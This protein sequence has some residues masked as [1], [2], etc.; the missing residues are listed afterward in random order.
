VHVRRVAV[1][2]VTSFNNSNVYRCCR[3]LRANRLSIPHIHQSLFKKETVFPL[4]YEINLCNIYIYMIHTNVR[5]RRFVSGLS[6][7]RFWF[8]PCSVRVRIVVEKL[9][10]GE[11]VQRV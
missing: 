5:L 11:V 4:Q 9:T 6:S 3:V 10:A 1:S 2:V 8:D 7:R